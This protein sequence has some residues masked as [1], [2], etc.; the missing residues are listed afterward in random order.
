[1]RVAVAVAWAAAGPTRGTRAGAASTP[2]ASSD[3][4]AALLPRVA[5]GDQRAARVLIDRHAGRVIA[6]AQR[7]LADGAEAEDVAQEAM[8]RLWR[9]ADSWEDRGAKLSTWLHRVTL[10][11]CYDRLRRRSKTPRQTP[12][13]DAPEPA[14]PA[15]TAEAQLAAGE[16]EARLEAALRSLPER[17]RAAIVLR[18]LEGRSNPDIAA[19]LEISVEAVESLLARGRRSLKARLTVEGEEATGMS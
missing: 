1:M 16:E 4:D 17:Q 6:T 18:H 14:D 15:P 2:G 12:L 11:L 5:A 3:E 10:N 7:L 8:L 13:D 19:A 9:A